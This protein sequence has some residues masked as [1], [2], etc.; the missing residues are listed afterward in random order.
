MKKIYIGEALV[1]NEL[2]L[3]PFR[4]YEGGKLEE[5][6]KKYPTLSKLMI[7]I[8]DLSKKKQ[9]K[10]KIAAYSKELKKEVEEA[11]NGGL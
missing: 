11:K 5:I 2:N 10:I 1:T 9:E 4:I 3:T 8:K 6:I 7:D